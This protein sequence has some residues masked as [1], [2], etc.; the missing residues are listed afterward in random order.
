M[1]TE[2]FLA[3][4]DVQRKFDAMAMRAK[5]GAPITKGTKLY[6]RIDSDYSAHVYDMHITKRKT[7]MF[8]AF[9]V[10]SPTDGEWVVDEHDTQ[11]FIVFVGQTLPAGWSHLEVTGTSYD[12]R[13]I[14]AKGVA[15]DLDELTAVYKYDITGGDFR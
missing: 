7:L 1:N 10:G 3:D 12:G 5:A 9:S 13:T 8:R 6:R 14:F 15:G 4:I 11:G 2:R